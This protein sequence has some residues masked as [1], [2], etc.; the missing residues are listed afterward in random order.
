MQ[1]DCM[2]S[3]HDIGELLNAQRGLESEKIDNVL[4]F[5]AVHIGP[6]LLSHHLEAH[7]V[8]S[9]SASFDRDLSRK[10]RL[11]CPIGQQTIVD[12]WQN[13]PMVRVGSPFLFLV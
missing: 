5:I 13:F 1:K 12:H 11:K 10:V 8:H 4:T 2:G 6:L 7:V 3:H 9:L